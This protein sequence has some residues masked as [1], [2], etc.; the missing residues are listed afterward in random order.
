MPRSRPLLIPRGEVSAEEAVSDSLACKDGEED[1]TVEV[2]AKEHPGVVS[3]F[4][5]S[6]LTSVQVEH[7]MEGESE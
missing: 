6:E 3:K 7:E 5:S 2:H 1:V 4:D